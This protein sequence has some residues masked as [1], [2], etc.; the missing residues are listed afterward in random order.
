MQLTDQLL[1]IS[2]N[3]YKTLGEIPKSE[4]RDEF[5]ETINGM[6]DKRGIFVENLQQEGFT[7]DAQNRVHCT[8]LDLDNGI[9]ERL[10]S[11]MNMVKKDMANLQKTKKNEEQY[12][13]P[14]SSVRVMDGMYYDKKK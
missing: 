2:A 7:F 5:I 3:L 11:V 1:Q 14:Y 12:S 10:S 6:L 9:K 4:D 13:N 8:L